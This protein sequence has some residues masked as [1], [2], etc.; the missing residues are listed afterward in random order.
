VCYQVEFKH[1]NLKYLIPTPTRT[2][3]PRTEKVVS[4]IRDVSG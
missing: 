2:T 1:N 3:A 4:Y